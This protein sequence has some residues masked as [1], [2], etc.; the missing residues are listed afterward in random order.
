[1][2]H[3]ESCQKG[4]GLS[5]SPQRWH[6]LSYTPPTLGCRGTH[7][8]PAHPALSNYWKHWDVREGGDV[9]WWLKLIKNAFTSDKLQDNH[10][11]KRSMSLVSW[12]LRIC[13]CTTV[14]GL[15][16]WQL[17]QIVNAHIRSRS[18]CVRYTVSVSTPYL[19]LT[20][21]V[22]SA[23][24]VLQLLCVQAPWWSSQDKH[25]LLSTLML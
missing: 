15:S 22:A 21:V 3:V 17:K 19:Q 8:A 24:S 25:S 18:L 2:G 20:A 9:G 10:L 6:Q 7:T 12:L 5:G 16:C 4:G 23:C 13:C 11:R 14:S 1:M